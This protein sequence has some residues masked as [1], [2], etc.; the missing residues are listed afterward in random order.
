MEKTF[1]KKR[2]QTLKSLKAKGYKREDVIDLF[3][4]KKYNIIIRLN[5]VTSYL[6]N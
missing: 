5:K 4:R 1:K 6:N 2:A 3:G